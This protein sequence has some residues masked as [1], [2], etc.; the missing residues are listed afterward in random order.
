MSPKEQSPSAKAAH[1]P[2]AGGHSHE[3][4]HIENT[5]HDE[6]HVVVEAHGLDEGRR[7][8]MSGLDANKLHGSALI[9]FL[10]TP[11]IHP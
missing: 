10:R 4:C 5:R 2:Y 6:P 3:L 8:V 7:V 1:G 9:Q 11:S